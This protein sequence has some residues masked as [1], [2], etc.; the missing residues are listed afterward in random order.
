MNLIRDKMRRQLLALAWG[1]LLA[2]AVALPGGVA[3]QGNTQISIGS[4]ASGSSAYTYYAS[5]AAILNRDL[6]GKVQATVIETGASVENVRRLAR[7]QLTMGLVTSDIAYRTYAGEGT[8]PNK[9][10]RVLWTYFIAPQFYVVRQDSAVSSVQGLTGKKFNPGFRGSA[11]ES[12]T[13]IIFEELQIKPEYFRATL[14]DSIAAVKDNRI[15]GYAKGGSPAS[16][17]STTMEIASLTPIRV[18]SFTDEQ[19]AKV[20]ARHSYITW[21]TLK[22]GDVSGLGSEVKTWAPMTHVATSSEALSEQLGYEIVKAVFNSQKEQA[23]TTP[24]IAQID[25]TRTLLLSSVPLHAGT[26]KYL[27]EIGVGIPNQLIPPEAR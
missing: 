17:D 26:V 8:E 14:D 1:S 4:T 2:G 18:L 3:A 12:T 23:Q 27:R 11:T 5:V 22:P 6:A 10:L 19:I 15:V 24:S 9:N 13:Q 16:L 21:L 25:F 20:R 7:K